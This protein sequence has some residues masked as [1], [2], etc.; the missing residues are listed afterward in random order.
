VVDFAPGEFAGFGQD[1]LPQ[2][3]L[4]GPRG[5]GPGQGGLDVLSLGREGTITLAFEDWIAVDGPGPDLLVFENPFPGWVEPGRV[6]VS[7]DGESWVAFPCDGLDADGGYPGCA[8][9]VP[10]LAH[11]D[12]NDLD[13]TD[14]DAAGG[15]AFDLADVGLA[16][17]R[18]IRITDDGTA[19]DFG[20]AGQA[21]GFDLDAVAVVNGA[22]P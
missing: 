21:G 4:G 13:P 20:Y 6:E 22:E 5:A 18:F 10:V 19:P 17:A 3:V 1:V 12:E 15:D 16:E 9:V 11:V 14:P 8:G 2:V 7:A